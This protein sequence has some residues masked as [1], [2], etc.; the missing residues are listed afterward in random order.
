MRVHRVIALVLLSSCNAHHDA[1]PV[2]PAGLELVAPGL[3]PLALLRYALPKGTKTTLALDVETK[4]AAGDQSS[5][6][7]PL[8]VA[9][10][11]AVDDVLP[12]GRMK[13]TSTIRSVNAT[14]DDP[15][16]AHI[17]AVGSGL[18]GLAITATLSPDGTIADVHATDQ[19]LPELAKSE[20]RAAAR[21][22][23]A[24]RDAAARRADRSRREMAQLPRARPGE[25]ARVADDHHR[26]G[27]R[28][29][30]LDVDVRDRIRAARRRS[31]GRARWR[32]HR[33]QEHHRHGERDGTIDLARFA[34]DATQTSELH[35]E[36]T[37][38]GSDRTPMTMT[39]TTHVSSH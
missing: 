37:T 24:A 11:V 23:P 3:P 29:H 15:T 5:V 31:N 36:M 22:V 27:H 18:G 16:S 35:M 19:P 30:P 10:D 13:L 8:H 14:G 38:S 28:A 6:A 32:V 21:R 9:L 34:V 7:P 4:I 17:D 1:P 39:T 33:R 12:D 25:L 2:E 26:R 20:L